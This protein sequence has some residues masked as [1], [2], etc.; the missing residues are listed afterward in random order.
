MKQTRSKCLRRYDTFVFLNFVIRVNTQKV[1][2][3]C[4]G[5]KEKVSLCAS[6]DS[7][8]ACYIA[9][10]SQACVLVYKLMELNGVMSFGF[11]KRALS[12]K[13]LTFSA[14]SKKIPTG[15]RGAEKCVWAGE[16]GGMRRKLD[17]KGTETQCLRS[18]IPSETDSEGPFATDSAMTEVVSQG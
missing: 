13:C 18:V 1:S 5:R 12:L 17:R 8:I 14:G 11:W 2:W 7:G 15:D 4:S 9:K 10:G 6:T 16:R 3:R